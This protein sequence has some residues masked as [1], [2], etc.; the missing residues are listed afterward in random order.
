MKIEE[1]AKGNQALQKEVVNLKDENARL[2][3]RVD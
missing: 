1:L 3:E 2:K